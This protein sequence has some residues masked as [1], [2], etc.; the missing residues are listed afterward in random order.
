MYCS[1][2]SFFLDINQKKFVGVVG[3]EPTNLERED[4][5]QSPAIAA[6]R[7]SHHITL[8]QRTCAKNAHVTINT[9]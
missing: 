1:R 8:F 6:M 3:L 5:L 4:D 2:S 9:I 7:H